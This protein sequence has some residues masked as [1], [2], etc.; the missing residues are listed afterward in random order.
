MGKGLRKALLIVVAALVPAVF[1]FFGVRG[2]VVRNAVVTAEVTTV[3]SPIEGILTENALAAGQPG[4]GRTGIAVGNPRVDSR[5]LDG[6]TAEMAQLLRDIE[7]RQGSL[8]WYEEQLETA[9]AR[10][11]AALSALRLELQLEQEVIA[12]EIKALEAR[13]EYLAAQYERAQRLQGTAASQAT[14]ELTAADLEETRAKIGSLRVKGEQLEQRMG[15]MEQGLPLTDY[16]DHAALLSERIQELKLQRQ[17]RAD[18]LVALESR[19]DALHDRLESEQRNFELA[20]HYRQAPPASAVVWEVFLGTGATVAE[21][22]TV[23]TYVDCDQR[24]VEVPVGDATSELLR[25][26]HPVTISLYGEGE[27]IEGRVAAVF[28]SAAG[29]AERR[30]LVAHVPD[31]EESEA[32]ALVAIPPADAES[33]AY[34]LCDLGRTA[35]VKFEGIGVLDPLFNRLW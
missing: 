1:L 29:L 34:R 21:G 25:P 17:Q 7:L 13:V 3:R 11:R 16:A 31:S 9:E 23:Y 33:R 2:F 18:E 5:A 14:L 19:L 32:I 8:A 28:G 6:V 22:A 24:F 30:T 20:S 27:T 15:F 35:Y 10:L 12:G 26:N 4:D